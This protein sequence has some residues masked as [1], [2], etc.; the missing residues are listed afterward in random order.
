MHSLYILSRRQIVASNSFLSPTG[1]AFFKEFC[2]SKQTKHYLSRVPCWLWN[3]CCSVP[4]FF[5]ST[6][7]AG[8]A[9]TINDVLFLCQGKK[10]ERK[11]CWNKGMTYRL[12]S[13]VYPQFCSHSIGCQSR[14]R[15][16]LLNG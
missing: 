7:H 6:A 2:G 14:S 1:S 4:H 5:H 11:H 8:K 16:K 13:D 15:E 3:G 10:R 12:T 9:D